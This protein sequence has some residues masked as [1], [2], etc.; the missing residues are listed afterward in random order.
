MSSDNPS[1]SFPTTGW[2]LIHVAADPDHPEHRPA[3]GL[4]VDRYYRPVY[5]FL[6]AR[7]LGDA[8]AL[9]LAQGFFLALLEDERLRKADPAIGP[10]RSFLKMHLRNFVADQLS[11]RRQD[12]Q[13]RWE[14]AGL[15]FDALAAY[16]PPA[17]E[18]PEQAFDRALARSI[19]HAAVRGLRQACETGRRPHDY[20]IFEAVLLHDGPSRPPTQDELAARFGMTRDVIRGILDRT[21]QRFVRLLRIELR[22]HGCAEA[23]LEA[24]VTELLK[25]LGQ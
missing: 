6:R 20:P 11:P 7:G 21:K 12:N 15:S 1:P 4:F 14:R 25:M 13:T 3:L 9:D 24:E 23:D 18:T 8:D 16:E 5:F 17:G 2:G 10:F 19:V 22:A